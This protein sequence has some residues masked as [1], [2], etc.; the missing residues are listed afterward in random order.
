MRRFP[1][2]KPKAVLKVLVV[3]LS[4]LRAN[5][6]SE[7]WGASDW[8]RQATNASDEGG[9]TMRGELGDI[10][11]AEQVEKVWQDALP[12]LLLEDSDVAVLE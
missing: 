8:V 12:C 9:R 7:R 10:S 1:F 6:S 4:L 3:S 5:H 11:G 2:Q